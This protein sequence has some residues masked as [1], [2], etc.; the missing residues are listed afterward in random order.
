MEKLPFPAQNTPKRFSMGMIIT[1][2]V[3]ALCI[4]PTIGAGRIPKKRIRTASSPMPMSMEAGI[5]CA[6]RTRLERRRP[7]KV[8]P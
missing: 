3:R 5:S 8:T 1:P 2:P 6:F 4:K 7:R